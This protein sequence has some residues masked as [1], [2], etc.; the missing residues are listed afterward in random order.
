M[1]AV[2]QNGFTALMSVALNGQTATVMALAQECG[3]DVNA[4]TE[5]SGF[6]VL[7]SAAQGGHTATIVALV[8]ECG[9]YVNAA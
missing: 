7:M 5:Q 8:Q 1:N 3:A 4:V 9:A 2:K 6:T